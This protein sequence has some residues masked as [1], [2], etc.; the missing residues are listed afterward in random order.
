MKTSMK[1]LVVRV[2]WGSTR[3]LATLLAIPFL[4]SAVVVI[5]L[6]FVFGD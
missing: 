4:I 2:A 6:R 1:M 5:G 3:P